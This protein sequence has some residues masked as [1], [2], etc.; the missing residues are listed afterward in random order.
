MPVINKPLSLTSVALWR[1]TS[2]VFQGTVYEYPTQ[3]KDGVATW[4][5]IAMDDT[6]NAQQRLIAEQ[7]ENASCLVGNIKECQGGQAGYFHVDG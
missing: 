5:A 7:L 4:V 2:C 6:Y 3:V 1:D